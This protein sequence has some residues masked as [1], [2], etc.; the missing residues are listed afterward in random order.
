MPKF[1]NFSLFS[2][3]DPVIGTRH[4]DAIIYDSNGTTKKECI[5]THKN[6]LLVFFII[7]IVSIL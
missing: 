6:A 5:S 2:L 4:S 1:D 7:Q 3:N